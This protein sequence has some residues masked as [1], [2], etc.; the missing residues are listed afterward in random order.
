MV[1][2]NLCSEESHKK[3]THSITRNIASEIVTSSITR[4]IYH[5]ALIMETLNTSETTVSDTT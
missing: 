4:A 3:S 5:I 2:E 1:E